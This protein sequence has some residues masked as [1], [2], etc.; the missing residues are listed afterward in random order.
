M[1]DSTQVQPDASLQK[2]NN[3]FSEHTGIKIWKEFWDR[4]VCY[5]LI[6]DFYTESPHVVQL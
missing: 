4:L 5:N 6:K 1:G 2:S 3:S